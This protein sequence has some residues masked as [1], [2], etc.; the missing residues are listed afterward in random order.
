MVRKDP[1]RASPKRPDAAKAR[2]ALHSLRAS[3]AKKS[4]RFEGMTEE[5]VIRVLK[6]TRRR[7][8]E[9]KLAVGA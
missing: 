2:A 6:E 5:E 3:L 1:R 7:L 8:W 4:S 9:R